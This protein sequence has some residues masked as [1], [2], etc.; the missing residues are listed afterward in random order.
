LLRVVKGLLEKTYKENEV[1]HH[2]E[3]ERS[4]MMGLA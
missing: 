3:R 2:V 1:G 4:R